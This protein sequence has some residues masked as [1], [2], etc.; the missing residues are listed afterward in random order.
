MLDEQGQHRLEQH[1]RS[2]AHLHSTDEQHPEAIVVGAATVK[3]ECVIAHTERCHA[4]ITGDPS[5]HVLGHGR[6]VGMEE[7]A[8]GEDVVFESQD[9][10]TVR[11]AGQILEPSDRLEG[12]HQHRDDGDGGVGEGE[13]PVERPDR[14][15]DQVQR[16]LVVDPQRLTLERG[17]VAQVPCHRVG[18]EI[19]RVGRGNRHPMHPDAAF[20]GQAMGTSVGRDDV[21][22]VASG[23]QPFRSVADLPS[24]AAWSVRRV[25][26]GEKAESQRSD[27][28]RQPAD[29]AP[30]DRPAE[31]RARRRTR[32]SSATIVRQPGARGVVEAAAVDLDE[33]VHRVERRGRSAPTAGARSSSSSGGYTIGVAKNQTCMTIAHR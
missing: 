5:I 9:R 4:D 28:F 30:E 21:D 11:R 33:P 27:L 25:L 19:Q 31:R 16:L 29:E 2:L 10:R 7:G 22:V 17:G 18:P 26:R 6:A 14:R 12:G 8:A 20:L 32:P 3:F 1:V 15:G 13:E 23:G 24:D